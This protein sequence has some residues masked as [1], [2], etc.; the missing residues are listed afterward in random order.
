MLGTTTGG[1]SPA[2]LHATDPNILSLAVQLVSS[3]L[4][5]HEHHQFICKNVIGDNVENLNEN[6]SSRNNP[7][8]DPVHSS[9]SLS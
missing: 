4:I 7:D 9:H 8:L 2:G 5:W 6:T 3:P 1:G